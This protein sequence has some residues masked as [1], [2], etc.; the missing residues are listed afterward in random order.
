MGKLLHRIGHQAARRP[1]RTA[2]VWLLV[3]MG[4]IAANRAWGG[5][6]TNSFDI[7]G[8]E[9]QQAVDLIEDRFPGLTGTTSRIVFHTEAGRLDDPAIAATIGASV[10]R[11]A[12]AR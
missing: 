6:P 9:S 1:G 5:E 7:P 3:A 4:T 10:P 8:A 11:H 2:L 12:C